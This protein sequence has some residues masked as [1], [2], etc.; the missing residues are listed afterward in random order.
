MKKNKLMPLT[1]VIN[2]IAISLTIIATIFFFL[3]FMYTKN[4][5]IE[6]DLYDNSF[7]FIYD[8]FPLFVI[9]DFI[10]IFIGIIAIP[11]TL[12][13][14]LE[15]KTDTFIFLNFLFLFISIILIPFILIILNH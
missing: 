10:S 2:G 9:I 5:G 12:K 11:L 1:S 13:T 8:K 6:K 3:T 14:R 7:I 15:F 4:S